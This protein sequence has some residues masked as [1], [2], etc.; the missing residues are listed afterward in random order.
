ML[1]PLVMIKVSNLAVNPAVR[2][3]FLLKVSNLAVRPLQINFLFPVLISGMFACGRAVHFPLFHYK[4]VSFSSYYLPETAEKSAQSLFL[5]FQAA[6][7]TQ[8]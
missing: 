7:L 2:K 5:P 8:T 4:I 3:T 6:K 1:N